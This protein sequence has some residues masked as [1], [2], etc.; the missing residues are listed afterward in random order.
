MNTSQFEK[1]SELTKKMQEPFQ[2]IADLN[3]K[4]VKEMSY[5]K[6]E[7]FA[8]PRKPEALFEKQIELAIDNGYKALDYMQKSLQ[9]LEKTMDTFSKESTNGKSK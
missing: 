5:L 6:P 1:W 7:D 4:A 3:L 8:M 9:I 2:A